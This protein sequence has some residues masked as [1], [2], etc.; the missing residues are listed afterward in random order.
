MCLT[1]EDSRFAP[2]KWSSRGLRVNPSFISR[3]VETLDCTRPRRQ[4]LDGL[5]PFSSCC[6][7]RGAR[8]GRAS[9]C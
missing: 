6:M 9:I 4:R 5:C 7:A 8:P 2:R 3:L 1:P